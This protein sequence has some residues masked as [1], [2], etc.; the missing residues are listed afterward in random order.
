MTNADQWLLPSCRHLRSVATMPTVGFLENYLNAWKVERNSGGNQL[1]LRRL[2]SQDSAK[3][4]DS[5]VLH[6]VALEVS[7][8]GDGDPERSGGSLCDLRGGPA[9]RRTA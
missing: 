2:T 3:T 7:G 1:Q 6:S 8:G 9:G 5:L 4:L